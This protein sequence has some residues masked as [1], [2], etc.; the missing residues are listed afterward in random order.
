MSIL[1]KY[2]SKRMVIYDFTWRDGYV[3]FKGPL[4]NYQYLEVTLL[5]LHNY[6]STSLFCVL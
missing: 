5:V 1:Y 6:H 2:I 4:N 3:I